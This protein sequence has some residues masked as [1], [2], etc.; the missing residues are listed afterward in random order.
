MTFKPVEYRKNMW[1]PLKL[2]AYL[3]ENIWKLIFYYTSVIKSLTCKIVLLSGTN[4][5]PSISSIFLFKIIT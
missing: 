4:N 3:V 1:T 2:G 5:F